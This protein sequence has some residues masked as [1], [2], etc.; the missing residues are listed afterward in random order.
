MHHI[1]AVPG[2]YAIAI[3]NSLHMHSQQVALE[4]MFAHVPGVSMKLPLLAFVEE[5][6]DRA[7]F[8]ATGFLEAEPAIPCTIIH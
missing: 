3:P 7:G 5:K 4:K 1:R 6:A 2:L 8:A